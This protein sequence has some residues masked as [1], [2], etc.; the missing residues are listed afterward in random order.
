MCK[1]GVDVSDVLACLR[2]GQTQEHTILDVFGFSDVFGLEQFGR[3]PGPV[4][5]GSIWFGRLVETRGPIAGH[6]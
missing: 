4:S 5:D 6:N 2:F 3:F 1:N